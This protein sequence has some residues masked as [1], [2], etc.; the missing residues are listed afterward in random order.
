MGRTIAI[1]T[2]GMLIAAAILVTNHWQIEPDQRTATVFRLNRWTGAV[3]MCALDA[4]SFA[5]PNSLAG[6]KLACEY[7]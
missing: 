1:L 6:A 2:G 5:S 4:K 3:D 7:R